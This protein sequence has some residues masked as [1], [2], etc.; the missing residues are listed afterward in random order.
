MQL[1]NFA[2]L[3]LEHVASWFAGLLT[4]DG[5]AVSSSV[6]AHLYSVRESKLGRTHPDQFDEQL[7]FE[8]PGEHSLYLF[9]L[10]A[11]A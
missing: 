7:L 10:Q 1:K 8:S 3:M 5:Q 2:C 4:L 6:S 11:F 9:V